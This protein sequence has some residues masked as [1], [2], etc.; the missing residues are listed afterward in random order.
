[1]INRKSYKVPE[2]INDITLGQ[3]M[4]LRD[5]KY[6]QLEQVGIILTN[7]PDEFAKLPANDTTER[8]ISNTLSL[9]NTLNQ[10][11]EDFKSSGQN[12][13]IPDSAELAGLK[14]R[15]PKDIQREPLG[16]RTRTRGIL[17]EIQ[18][19]NSKSD[20]Y[21]DE[22]LAHYLYVPFVS[23][24]TGEPAVYNEYR[25]DE[26]KEIVK[27]L[28]LSTAIQLNIFFLIRSK[29]FFKSKLRYWLALWTLYSKRLALRYL[30][31]TV[32]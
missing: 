3:Y 8:S 23:V 14:I 16:A 5:N 24:L 18:K 12:I 31:N 4:M 7:N 2:T 32:T 15:I 27:Q 17:M 25:A 9:L 22:V 20:N 26:F 6:T 28:P 10:N 13:N 19:D 29:V 11:I 30:T 21:I 1:M